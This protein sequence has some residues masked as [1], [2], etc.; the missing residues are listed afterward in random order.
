[1]INR[2]SVH[3][4]LPRVST[5]VSKIGEPSTARQLVLRQGDGNA[6]SYFYAFGPQIADCVQ[7]GVT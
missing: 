1:M 7:A 5:E 3:P 6:V 4:W 2:V